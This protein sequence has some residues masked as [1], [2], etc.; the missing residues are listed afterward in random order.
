MS[1]YHIEDDDRYPIKFAVW[2]CGICKKMAV[3]THGFRPGRCS[4]RKP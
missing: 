1:Y 4:C 3:T 2:R